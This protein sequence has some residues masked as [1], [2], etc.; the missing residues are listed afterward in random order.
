[1]NRLR[2]SDE[3]YLINL[4]DEILGIK[5]SRQQKFF[6]LRVDKGKSVKDFKIKLKS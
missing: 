1:M 6:F 4:C 2:D 5:G 3:T